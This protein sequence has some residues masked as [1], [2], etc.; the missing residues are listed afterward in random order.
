MS[1]FVCVC[2]SACLCVCVSVCL[3][4]SVCALSMSSLPSF[5]NFNSSSEA[6]STGGWP[7]QVSIYTCEARKV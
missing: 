7:A 3:S 1:E 6:Q 2:V 5:D 4:V